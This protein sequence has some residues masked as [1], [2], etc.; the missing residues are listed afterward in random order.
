MLSLVSILNQNKML[1]KVELLV[2][3]MFSCKHS[4]I[5]QELKSKTKDM[6]NSLDR[7][8]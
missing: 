4:K 1:F 7:K 8:M 6:E 2:L 3:N 5:V